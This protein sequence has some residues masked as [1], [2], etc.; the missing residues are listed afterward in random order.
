MIVYRLYIYIVVVLKITKC[1]ALKILT[2]ITTIT[3]PI[4]IWIFDYTDSLNFK[5]KNP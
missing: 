4:I 2:A 3:I 1:T 5:L